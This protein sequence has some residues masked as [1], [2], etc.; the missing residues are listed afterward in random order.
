[1]FRRGEGTTSGNASGEPGEPLIL[2]ANP[3]VSQAWGRNSA[4]GISNQEPGIPR[5]M[6]PGSC[7]E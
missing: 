1:M 2:A 5:S 3:A 6:C 7:R 4:G